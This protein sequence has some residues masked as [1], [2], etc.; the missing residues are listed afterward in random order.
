MD[1]SCSTVQKPNVSGNRTN[2]AVASNLFS[3]M[4]KIFLGGL[5]ARTSLKRNKIQVN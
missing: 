2:V 5:Q 1:F 3:K 4:F